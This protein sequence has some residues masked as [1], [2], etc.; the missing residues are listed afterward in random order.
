MSEAEFR[1]FSREFKLQVINWWKLPVAGQLSL[2]QRTHAR[3]WWSSIPTGPRLT[4]RRA[5]DAVLSEDE[6]VRRHQSR[7][8]PTPVTP[9]TT[10]GE[11]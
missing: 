8:F 6:A 11:I 5:D 10:P 3:P 9:S 7:R 2:R 4:A 1:S